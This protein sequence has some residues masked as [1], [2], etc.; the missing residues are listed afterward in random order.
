LST[1]RDASLIKSGFASFD[2]DKLPEFDKSFFSSFEVNDIN[3]LTGTAYKIEF[4]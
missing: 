2:E 4:F 3:S 1:L